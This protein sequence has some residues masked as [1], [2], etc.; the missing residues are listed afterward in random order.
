MDQI[1]AAS[2]KILKSKEIFE[3]ELVVTTIAVVVTELI[4]GG[5]Y[6]KS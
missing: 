1:D 5:L 6:R 2:N 4:G 3:E